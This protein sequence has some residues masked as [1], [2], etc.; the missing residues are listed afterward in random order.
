VKGPT[1]LTKSL[2]NFWN[3][4][5]PQFAASGRVDN[6]IFISR[7]LPL[8]DVLSEAITVDNLP[9]GLTPRFIIGK[10]SPDRYNKLN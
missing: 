4:S 2:D 3:V 7:L 10:E 8:K 5:D 9:Q 1:G 6:G